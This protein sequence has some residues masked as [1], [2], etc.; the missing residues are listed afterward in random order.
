LAFKSVFLCS[1]VFGKKAEVNESSDII[2]GPAG[3]SPHQ[4][5]AKIMDGL[6]PGL[7]VPY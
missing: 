6:D 1:G 3:A 5:S 4:F 7:K 2:L